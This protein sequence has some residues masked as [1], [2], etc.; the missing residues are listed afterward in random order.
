MESSNRLQWD[1]G[2]FLGNFRH[3]LRS[4]YSQVVANKASSILRVND[5]VYK[6]TLGRNH[7][8]GKARRVFSR[9]C[10]NIL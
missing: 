1:V 8:I 10:F 5:V 6:A 7:G 4:E 9:V 2:V 3:L